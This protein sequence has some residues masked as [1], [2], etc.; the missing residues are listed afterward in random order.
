MKIC[1]TCQ[2]SYPNAFNACP[3]DGTALVERGRW[4]D[5]AVICDK[6]RILCQLGQGG[7]GTV[8]KALHIDFEE[9]RALKVINPALMADDT[10]VKR[11]KHEAKITRK[12]Q[13]PN[14]VRVDDIDEAEDGR[15]FM[16]M[17]YIEGQSLKK[18]IQD[19]GPLPA[20][21]TCSIIKQAASALGAAHELGMVHRDIKPDN[22]V[23]INSPRGEQVKVLDFGIAKVKE[24]RL[25][26]EAGAVT[27]TKVGEVIGT[28]QYMSPEQAMGKRGDELD[29]RS[30]LYSLG[31]VMYQMLSGDLPFKADTT[32][33]MILAHL[34][35]PPAPLATIHP[36]LHIPAPLAAVVMRLLEKNRD[37]RPNNAVALIEALDR[38]EK[39][40]ADEPAMPETR[41][42]LPGV[43]YPTN[44]AQELRKSLEA[45]RLRAGGG[46]AG[47][48]PPG[49]QQEQPRSSP[50]Q[51]AAGDASVRPGDVPLRKPQETPGTP[52]IS[53]QQPR[54]QVVSPKVVPPQPKSQWG[55]W[56]SLGILFLG[57]GGGGVYYYVTRPQPIPVIPNPVP[58]AVTEKSV[59]PAS[60]LAPTI[61]T[62][63]NPAFTVGT[64]GSTT[65]STTGKPSPTISESGTLPR[66]L[67]FDPSTGAI[68]GTPESGTM[69]TYA[70]T[71]TATNGVSPDATR[72][73][74]IEVKPAPEPPQPRK[75]TKAVQQAIAM[76]DFYFNRGMYDAA[77]GEYNKGLEADPTN[78]KLKSKIK[79]ARILGRH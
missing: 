68:S 67:S 69:G 31:V 74:T 44:A 24:A 71:L 49:P 60:T 52:K 18:L 5:G 10:F 23:L 70:I 65:M 36:E 57:L 29:G 77:I 22:I 48:G 43:G 59:P 73:V 6:Y 56:V 15:P 19:V 42:V 45:N 32:M 62:V 38:A 7:M 46:G 50:S 75:D 34:Q 30:D 54:Q 55:L 79:A 58:S 66:G 78:S 1:P 3:E 63:S 12:L 51:P 4:S 53:Q 33:A 16:V 8:Y 26:A 40:A 28:P 17:E 39:M 14:A 2:N 37:L 20:A 72:S 11:F 35:T 64:R 47:V 76:G 21:R 9:P 41:V 13:H 25:G 27:L 61:G